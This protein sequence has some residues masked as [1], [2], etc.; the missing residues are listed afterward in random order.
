VPA[1]DLAGSLFLA[2]AALEAAGVAVPVPPAQAEQ[3]VAALLAEGLLL[4][5]VPAVLPHLPVESAT[6]REVEAIV[7]AAGLGH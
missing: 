2:R 1:D 5:E 3:L 7:A 6:L 4:E